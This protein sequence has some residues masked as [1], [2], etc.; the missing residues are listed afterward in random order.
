[1][2]PHFKTHLDAYLSFSPLIVA[3][4]LDAFGIISKADFA[5]RAAILVKGEMLVLGTATPLKKTTHTLRPDSGSHTSFLS[6]RTTTEKYYPA[7]PEAS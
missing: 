4:G 2:I 1:M 7:I 5:N 6:G 3:Y